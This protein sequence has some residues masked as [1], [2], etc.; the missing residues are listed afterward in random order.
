MPRPVTQGP[1]GVNAAPEDTA[2][3]SRN[4]DAEY[5]SGDDTHDELEAR[6]RDLEPVEDNAIDDELEA[7]L[8]ARI[9]SLSGTH[10]LTRC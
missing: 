4:F 10:Q 2:V 9:L 5:D 8:D 7:K 6:I 1:S 3:A